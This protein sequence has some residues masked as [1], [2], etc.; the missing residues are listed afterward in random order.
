MFLSSEDLYD[1]TKM[2]QNDTIKIL[3][4][5]Q[6]LGKNYMPKGYI[7]LGILNSQNIVISHIPPSTFPLY[8]TITKTK[9][10]GRPLSEA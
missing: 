9:Q 1:D 7:H 10:Q 5:E 3:H 2:Y 4:F 8:T 6:S